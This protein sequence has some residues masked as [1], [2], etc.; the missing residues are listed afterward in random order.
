[1]STTMGG[2]PEEFK[3][4]LKEVFT[5]PDVLQFFKNSFKSVI[6]QENRELAD[7]LRNEIGTLRNIIKAKNERIDKLE[8]KVQH[9]EY[10]VDEL[11]QYSRRNS[12]RITGISEDEHEDVN[13][14]VLDLFNHK[15]GVSTTIEDIDR[16]HRVGKRGNKPRAVLVK[17]ATYRA[18]GAVFKA[19]KFLK[20]GAPRPTRDAPAWNL[21]TAA[22]LVVDPATHPLPGDPVEPRP[23][24]D[25]VIPEPQEPFDGVFIAEDLT[26]VRKT[27]LYCCRQA[28]RAEKIM[29]CW[30]YDG[31]VTVKDNNGHIVQIKT[32]L[33]LRQYGYTP[34]D[35][36]RN[37]PEQ[38]GQ[39]GG[40]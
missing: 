16:M 32:I 17:F 22:G 38:N 1:M 12:I 4:T 37:R 36:S 29:D 5:D 14:R 40:R 26:E 24:Q 30:S 35:P 11:E 18:R 9:L 7:D 20:P 19:K 2:T 27:L 25:A 6:Q 39:T 10:T 15:M 8:T 13:K 3:K 31:R 21:G 33:D 23:R 28:R 34:A